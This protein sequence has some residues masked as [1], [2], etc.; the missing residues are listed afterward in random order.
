VGEIEQGGWS[1]LYFNDE[2]AT[3]QSE[4]LVASAALLPYQ[5]IDEFRLMIFPVVLGT[6]TRLFRDRSDQ[7]TL[8]LID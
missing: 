1:N 4:Q 5:L 3:W 8:K 6:G 2:L 7:T